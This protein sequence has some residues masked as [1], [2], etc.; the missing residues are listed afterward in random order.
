[1]K[2]CF[3]VQQN[4]G[5]ES[6]AFNHFGSAPAFVAVDAASP[7]IVSIANRDQRHVHGA[8]NPLKALDNQHFVDVMLV[9]L[10]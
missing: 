10:V 2:V 5:P 6:A 9:V 8:C 3:P 7:M 1:M 4:E